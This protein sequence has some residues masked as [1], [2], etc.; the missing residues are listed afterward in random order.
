M[1]YAVVMFC[2]FKTSAVVS[3][4]AGRGLQKVGPSGSV[5]KVNLYALAPKLPFKSVNNT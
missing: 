4:G 3:S 1:N 5:I 2:G